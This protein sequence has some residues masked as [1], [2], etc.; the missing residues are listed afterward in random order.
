[1]GLKICRVATDPD[2]SLS[3]KVVRLH[4]CRNP[5]HGMSS[6]LFEVMLADFESFN[7]L[8]LPPYKTFEDLQ[9]KL[10]WAVEETVGFGQ[11]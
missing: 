4:I 11:E 1:M 7:R 3:R 10:T 5:I 2:D 8:D 9:K 6:G